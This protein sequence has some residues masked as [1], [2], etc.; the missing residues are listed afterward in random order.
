[1]FAL[2][3]AAMGESDNELSANH[4]KDVSS[5][6][7]A[8]LPVQQIPTQPNVRLKI[9][10]LTGWLLGCRFKGRDATPESRRGSPEAVFSPASQP[11][12]VYACCR[13]SAVFC[14]RWQ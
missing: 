3:P 10:A 11:T 2:L 8:Q 6:V 14:R 7:F 13:G 4:V 12:H 1:M 9:Q 5:V